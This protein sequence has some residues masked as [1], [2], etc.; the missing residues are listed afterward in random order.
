MMKAIA[1]AFSTYS[2]I[3]MPHFKWDPKALQYS[4]C[5]FPLVG[6]VIGAGEFA[7]WYLFGFLLQWSEVFTAA[8]LMVF[9]IL[10]TGGI[11]MDGFLDTVDAKSSYKSKE[12]KLQILKDPHTGAFAIIRGCLYFLIYFGC[13][14]E[15]VHVLNRE[16][17]SGTQAGAPAHA[18][19]L[20]GVFAVGFVL[21]RT[22]SGLS[23][24]TFQKAKKEGM[25]ADTARLVN[26]RS[27]V[28][29]FVWLIAC[30]AAGCVIQ[31]VAA[32]VITGIAILMF[33][34]YRFMS[35]RTF[36]GITGDL[37]GYFLQMCELWMLIG[38]VVLVHVI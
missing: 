21:E 36:G 13:M 8:L 16:I 29:M 19:Q 33:F 32:L 27:K 28:I 18:M 9:P 7:I 26:N 15:V 30:S 11:H 34:Y 22:L 37:A 31:P 35:Y 17:S 23:V 4:M 1:I 12:E 2:K 20:M 5:A 6:A 38:I 25:L 14:A 3:P 24:L 10:I